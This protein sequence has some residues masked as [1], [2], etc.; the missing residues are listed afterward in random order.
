MRFVR[1]LVL[2]C[3]QG[4]MFL[5]SYCP[6]HAEKGCVIPV[7]LSYIFC[8]MYFTPSSANCNRTIL[9]NSVFCSSEY[10]IFYKHVLMNDKINKSARV[11]KAQPVHFI[12]K[13]RTSS[14]IWMAICLMFSN[15]FG[16]LCVRSNIGRLES[17]IYRSI[18]SCKNNFY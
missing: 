7:F 10:V 5:I 12:N 11:Y 13:Y 2:K 8:L 4:M 14:L 15:C 16:V 6:F 18:L 17:R 3:T 9:W 1:H